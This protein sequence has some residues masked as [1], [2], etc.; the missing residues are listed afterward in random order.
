VGVDYTAHD[1]V[2]KTGLS[3]RAYRNEV[4]AYTEWVPAFV[5]QAPE[6]WDTLLGWQAWLQEQTGLDAAEWTHLVTFWN[7]AGWTDEQTTVYLAA[8]LSPAPVPPASVIMTV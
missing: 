5:D 1:W 2:V 7:S 3:P 6:I 4:R 8:R